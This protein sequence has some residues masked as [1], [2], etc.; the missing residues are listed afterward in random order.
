MIPNKV[1]Q[2]P[3]IEIGLSIGANCTKALEPQEVIPSK[4]MHW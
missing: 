4:V 3:D 2:E 1:P